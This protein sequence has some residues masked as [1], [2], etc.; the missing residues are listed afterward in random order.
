MKLTFGNHL[1]HLILSGF[2]ALYV[3]TTEENRCETECRAVADRLNELAGPDVPEAEQFRFITWDAHR[4]FSVLPGQ[5]NKLDPVDALDSL[6]GADVANNALVSKYWG[7]TNAIF[8]FRSLHDFFKD[9]VVRQAIRNLVINNSLNCPFVTQA[10][11]TVLDGYRRPVIVM[12]PAKDIHKDIAHCFTVVPFALPDAEQL[13]RV[14]DNVA[15]SVGPSQN[16]N[17]VTTCPAELR[18]RIVQ[19]MRGL[20]EREA[21]DILSMSIRINRGF[22][23]ADAFKLPNNRGN[24]GVS[25]VVED[26]KAAML[27]RSEVLTYISADKI[28]A[29]DS[30]GGNDILKQWM[31]RKSTALGS[32]GREFKLDAPRGLVLLGVPGT[33][34]STIAKVIARILK[35]PLI[36]FNVARLGGSLVG[37]SQQRTEDALN[38]IDAFDGAVVWIDEAEKAV[39][40]SVAGRDG[41]GGTQQQVF[42]MINTWLTE[43]ESRSFVVLTMNRIA[44]VPEEFLRKGRFDEV[45]YIP[46]PSR[47]TRKEILEIHLRK[48][49]CDPATYSTGLQKIVDLTD[50]FSGA[51]LEQI[52]IDAREMAVLARQDGIPTLDEMVG[53]A[54]GIKPLARTRAE[55]IAA[56]QRI[57][58][59]N[60]KYSSS[61]DVTEAAGVQRNTRSILLA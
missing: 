31:T 57:A 53:V 14:F 23:V 45:F 61:P 9:A 39:A 34:K 8:V 56:M 21:E 26:E 29:E 5:K 38:Q 10:D 50:D 27:Q 28:A 15:E 48:R 60:G 7:R 20:R 16:A 4:G 32:L 55:E 59:E 18:E 43:H 41:T 52:V 35:L 2:Q 22:N 1:E 49:G 30:I 6:F 40:G 58:E 44:G 25:E 46:L 17:A 42:G 36:R 54:A 19:A 51:E 24:P 11:G 37:E 33:G 13:A 12:S 47:W 3:T